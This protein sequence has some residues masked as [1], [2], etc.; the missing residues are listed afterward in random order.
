M[1]TFGKSVLWHQL[2]RLCFTLCGILKGQGSVFLGETTAWGIENKTLSPAQK[3]FLG[4]RYVKPRCSRRGGRDPGAWV[5]ICEWLNCWFLNGH[6]QHL[7][8]FFTL[9]EIQKQVERYV[10]YKDIGGELKRHPRRWESWT[11]DSEWGSLACDPLI[12]SPL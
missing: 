3:T 2:S 6:S 11:E 9:M 7:F 8:L 10:L 12:Q 5:C 1:W 4:T